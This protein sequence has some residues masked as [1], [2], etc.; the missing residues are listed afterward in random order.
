MSEKILSQDEV[1]ALLG[2]MKKGNVEL[3]NNGIIDANI[4]PL[5]LTVNEQKKKIK[6]TVLDEVLDRF[7]EMSDYSISLFLQKE[8]RFEYVAT[9]IIKF[10]EYMAEYSRP[11]IFN[12]FTMDPL[13]GKAIMTIK[14]QLVMSLID[15]MMGGTGNPVDKVREFTPLEK[16]LIN[17]FSKKL[18]SEFEKSWENIYPLTANI[19]K[20]ESNPDYIH[21]LSP[22]DNIVKIDFKI[23]GA[24]FKGNI[25]FCI[26]YLM[27]EPLKEKLSESYLKDKEQ[28]PKQSQRV[29]KLIMDAEIDVVAE[30]GKSEKTIS[31]LINLKINDIIR[32]QNGP[33]DKVILKVCG[34]PKYEGDPG[35][36]K[37][38]KAV[39]IVHKYI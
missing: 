11:T 26:S 13:I 29:K 30:L 7:F 1:E 23:K 36:M 24:E 8:I 21:I 2:A 37:G 22:S 35:I 31:E 20:V 17:K 19:V 9:E 16:R 6:F 12:Y 27:L 10:K 14:P 18:I 32:L 25:N 38:N 15:C 39:E 3:D 5:D 34:I 4:E 28:D 33:D